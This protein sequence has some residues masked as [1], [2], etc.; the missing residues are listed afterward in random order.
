MAF[1]WMLMLPMF[2]SPDEDTHYDYALTLYSAGRPVKAS[3]DRVGRDT[4]PIV[5]YLMRATHARQQRLDRNV[6]ADPGYGT[7]D[8]FR[9]LDKLAPQVSR[10]AFHDNPIDPAPYISKVYQIGYY[11]LVAA[12]I[13]STANVSHDSAVADFFVAR[14]LSVVLL[15][16]TLIFT[17]LSLLRL[18]IGSKRA[19][20][21]LACIALFTLSNWTAASIQPDNLAY[22][23]VTA[24]L[25]LALRLRDNP[26]NVALQA[27]LG[28]L[29]AALIAVKQHYFAAVCLSTVA[30]L[31][32]RLNFGR[33]ALAGVRCFALLAIPSVFSFA[34]TQS[35]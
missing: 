8:Y 2:L 30:M 15:V 27:L 35:F 24:S 10:T 34:A 28:L 25:Y 9:N 4:H 32:P 33:Y 3:E 31:A 13:A 21:V 7:L 26:S 16:P 29:F 1:A 5:E 14:F 22:F 6:G 12:V 20:L 23:L 11:A 17:W 18:S 19:L